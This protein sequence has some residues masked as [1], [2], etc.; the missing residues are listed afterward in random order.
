MTEKA[1]HILEKLAISPELKRARQLAKLVKG[2]IMKIP[3]KIMKPGGVNVGL[4]ETTGRFM[5]G[6][7]P[8]GKVVIH[9][10]G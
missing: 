8:A 1:Q 3:A 4:K 9:K 7:M 6:K 10:Q 2:P 5:I